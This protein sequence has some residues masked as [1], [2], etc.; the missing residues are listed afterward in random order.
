MNNISWISTG[1]INTF[2]Q[3]NN[4][5]SIMIPSNAYS[6]LCFYNALKQIILLFKGHNNWKLSKYLNIDLL[7]ENEFKLKIYNI[8]LY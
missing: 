6:D 4:G 8:Y 2:Y 5:N 3:T 1:E 7:M